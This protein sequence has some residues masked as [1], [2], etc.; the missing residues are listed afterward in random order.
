MSRT[1]LEVQ[2]AFLSDNLP[3]FRV[4]R[5]GL[6]MR[7]CFSEVELWGWQEAGASQAALSF[8]QWPTALG[9]SRWG[10]W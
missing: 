3:F 7:F 9:S 2:W 10:S 4:K 5:D 8:C 6:M 1:T